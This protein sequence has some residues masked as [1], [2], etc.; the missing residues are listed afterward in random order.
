M[1]GFMTRAIVI[2]NK[3]IISPHVKEKNENM[4]DYQ[5]VDLNQIHFL[6]LQKLPY[7]IIMRPCKEI[8][9][10]Y[11]MTKLGPTCF[12]V[13]YIISLSKH[14]FYTGISGNVLFHI[15]I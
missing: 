10:F 1:V 4:N 14:I 5:E 6:F 8:F 13:S 7:L 15:I 12:S 3:L 9:D 11:C 2:L